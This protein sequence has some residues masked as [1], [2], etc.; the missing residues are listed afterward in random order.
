MSCAIPAA[1]SRG[2][3]RHRPLIRGR[4]AAGGGTVISNG[5]VAAAVGGLGS[6]PITLA[7]GTLLMT[8]LQGPDGQVYLVGQ[9]S[10]L[11]SA[12]SGVETI[13]AAYAHAIANEYRFYSYGDACLLERAAT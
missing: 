1:A 3:H 6:G 12:F 8:P 13:R 5:L 7:G 4:A 2:R 10:M 9:G 11:V